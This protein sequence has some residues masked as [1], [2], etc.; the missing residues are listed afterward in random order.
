M[1]EANAHLVGYSH[2]QAVH[3]V[4]LLM[5]F[6]GFRIESIPYCPELLSFL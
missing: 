3:T 2:H 4:V 5:D 6:S 1:A